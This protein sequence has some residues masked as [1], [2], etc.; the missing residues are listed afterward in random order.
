MK[1]THPLVEALTSG[2]DVRKYTEGRRGRLP[3]GIV[4]KPNKQTNIPVGQATAFNPDIALH[5]QQKPNLNI[6]KEKP[7][8][9]FIAILRAQGYSLKDVFVQMGG[10]MNEK[11]QPI[12]GTGKYTYSWL[13][14]INRQAWFTKQVTRLLEEAGKDKISAALE[15]EAMTSLDTIVELRDN[16]DMDNV[17]LS[18]SKDILDRFLGKATNKIESK[19]IVTH[20]KVSEDDAR[21]DRELEE[22]ERSLGMHQRETN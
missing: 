14:Q 16:S 22:L 6:I 1:S 4:A 9:R 10:E 5:N 19:S 11:N 13:S 15:T 17:R 12:A 18:A 8:H 7:E 21:I 3:E 2:E 20:E